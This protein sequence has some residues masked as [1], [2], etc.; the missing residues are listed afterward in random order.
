MDHKK[1]VQ[2]TILIIF[3]A[4]ILSFM[5]FQKPVKANI[6]SL[7]L[8][9]QELPQIPI[10]PLYKITK[11]PSHQNIHLDSPDGPVVADL[12]I[13]QNS[14]K[15]KPALIIAMGVK[16]SDKDKPVILGFAE[17]L[18]RLGFIVLW[19]RSEILEQGISDFEK[20]STFSESYRFLE[21]QEIVNKNR[22]SFV[23]F[24]VGSSIAFSA[25]ADP[26]ISGKTRS[27]IFF[28]GYYDVFEYLENLSSQTITQNGQKISWHPD[29]SATNHVKEILTFNNSQLLSL[30]ND[31]K[32]QK[33]AQEI[34]KS[35]P[36]NE[37]EKFKMI[38]PK[39]KIG[40]YKTPTFILHERNDTFVPYTQSLALKTALPKNLQKSYLIINLFEHVQPQKGFSPKILGEIFKLYLFLYQTLYFLDS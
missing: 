29:Q 24:S 13:S 15:N 23:G 7:L 25:I 4:I 34:L 33:T 22:I 20:P 36:Q 32:S 18:S 2:R 38:S 8:I 17:T 26:Q 11:T 31:P 30:F 1:K 5:I 40:E 12:F 9:S 28:G 39:E 19:P 35:L 27:L 37:I 16:T 10:K 14:K 3:G 6:K 21:N